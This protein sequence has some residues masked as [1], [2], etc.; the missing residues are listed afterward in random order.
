M[1]D[2]FIIRYA[3]GDKFYDRPT[4]LKIDMAATDGGAAL[5]SRLAVSWYGSPQIFVNWSDQAW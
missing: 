3:E 1:R 5:N 2:P 4:E